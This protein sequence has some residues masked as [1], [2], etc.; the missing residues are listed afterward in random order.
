MKS[1]VLII[2]T[3]G[4]IGMINDAVTGKLRSFDFNLIT[5]H[6]P[7]LKRLNV[8]LT[9]ISFEEPMDSSNMNPQAWIKIARWI[10]ENYERYDGFVVLHGSDTMAYTAS[11][12]SFMFD[13]LTK[14]VII[15]GSQLPI[16]TIRTDGKENLITAI[17]VAAAK[18][19]NGTSIVQEVAI[20]FEYHLY[21]G[22][23]S[24]KDSASNFEA[25][26]SP[27]FTELAAA[28]VDIV[29][30]RDLLY[31]PCTQE[32]T[33][34]E[35]LNT[36]IGLIK[37]Y[38]GIDFSIYKSVFDLANVDGI[39]LETFGA[40]NAPHSK[41]LEEMCTQFI[42]A[43]GYILNI[44]QCNAGKVHQGLYETSS[45]FEKIGVVPGADLTTEAAITKMMIVL[46]AE[47]RENTIELLRQ[48]IRGE[49]S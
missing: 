10:Q 20:Y 17:E 13:G 7:E 8:D 41:S 45:M 4:T 11:A 3:G 25:I 44:T 22:N 39:V 37:I 35:Q 6:V 14:P 32:F 28:G 19:N 42:A 21:R 12:L 15:T 43:G 2:Y 36:R 47:N 48:N 24:T 1:K 30:N 40:G 31:R 16:G 33:L 5:D 38:P 23:R 27:N 29:Y 26:K 34:N 9:S 46:G 49:L 18:D